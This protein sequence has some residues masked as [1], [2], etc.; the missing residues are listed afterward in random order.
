MNNWKIGK[1]LKVV[2]S[3]HLAVLG[4][5][6]LSVLGYDIPFL[7][8][9]V[10]FIYLTFVPGLLILRILRLHRLGTIETLLYSVGLSIA[11][12]MFLGFFVNMLYPLIGISDPISTLPLIITLTIAVAILCVVAY[13]RESRETMAHT[14]HQSMPWSEILS[15]PA[16]FLLLL[17]LLSVLGAYYLANFHQNN[18]LL[19]ILIGLIALVAALVAFNKFIPQRLYPLAVVTIAI[20]LLWHW[21]LISQYLTGWDIQWEYYFQNLV[22]A[23]SSWDPALPFTYNAVLSITM[24]APIY[25]LILNMDTVWVFKIVYPLFFSLVPL[26]LFQVFRKETDDR[27]AFM[28]AFFFMSFF[29]FFTAMLALAR[30]QIAKLFFALSILLLL[31][32]EMAATKRAAL[33]IIFG[34]SVIVSHYG[35]SYFY[36]G[37]LLLALL[38]LSLARSSA[39]SNLWA[40]LSARF[41]KLRPCHSEPFASCCSEGAKRLKNLAQGD[42]INNPPRSTLSTTFVMLIVVFGL[43]WFIYIAS[44][45]PFDSIVRIGDHLYHHLG[46]F[47]IAGTRDP[48]ILLA[49]GLG[50]PEVASVQ[51]NIN[52]VIQYITQLFV[53]VGVIGLLFNRRKTR[54]QPLYIAMTLVSA[55]LLVMGIILPYF[56]GFF[57]MFRIY[58]IALF[59]LAPFCIL[60]G[61][62]I[63]RW[64][65]RLVPTRAL[66]TSSNPIYLKL[67]V[68]LVLIPYF[69]FN[70]GFIFEVSGDVP[71]SIALNAEMDFPRFNEH[72][73]S[74]KRWLLLNKEEPTKVVADQYGWLLLLGHIPRHQ[75]GTFWGETSDIA[76]NTYIYLRSWNIKQGEVMQS[77]EERRNYIELQNSPFYEEVITHRNKI[78]D[79]GSAQVY[80]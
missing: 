46:E 80:R 20:S 78:Y 53:V 73:L 42:K 8:Q 59:F 1:F 62:T 2:L 11:F 66:R 9:I 37:Y 64:L 50:S 67:V 43:A 79:N 58:H 52:L 30:M 3:I 51:R 38:L 7:T 33:L 13:I 19:L 48:A 55:L 16:L 34:F 15:P 77:W 17:P 27:I 75:L 70:T 69:L 18:I 14:G 6:G 10:G 44:G 74:G 31:D 40:G 21:S 63:F 28:A 56:A 57:H 35:L 76:D 32:K 72:E 60:G 36:M 5:I 65:F 29:P 39:V 24:L 23:N 41:S 61:I 4:A 12:V 26:A 71:T 25:S 68:M 45:S 54:F 49:L 47:L 22:L